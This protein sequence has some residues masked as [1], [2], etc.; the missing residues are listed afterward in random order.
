MPQG[1]FTFKAVKDVA[2][3]GDKFEQLKEEA[4]AAQAAQ[5]AKEAAVLAAA[6]ERRRQQEEEAEARRQEVQAATEKK[7]VALANVRRI[8]AAMKNLSGDTGKLLD[9]LSAL[10]DEEA[11]LLR[12]LA[13][14]ELTPEE[15]AA[16][17]A[18][19]AEI[20]AERKLLQANLKAN[21]LDTE[22]AEL[23]R[24]L[25]ALD[26]EEAELM[27]RL[28]A[29]DLSPEEEAAIRKRLA[30]IAA[31]RGVLLEQLAAKAAEQLHAAG[32]ARA[33]ELAAKLAA[34]ERKLGML[35]DEEAELL[36][37]LAAGDLTPEEEAAIRKRLAEIAAEREAL[38]REKS[39]ILAAEHAARIA[40][41]K[42]QDA[43]MEAELKRKLAALDDEEAELRRRLA[44][45]DLTPEEEAAIRK[46]LAEIEAE[47]ASLQAQLAQIQAQSEMADV[48]D[49]LAALDDEEA[50]LLRRLAAG[51]L[52][53]EEEAAIRKRLAEIAA[54]RQQ[55]LEQQLSA[56][57]SR[58]AALDDEEAELLRRLAA[59]D[60]TPEEEAAIRKRLAEIE[61]ERKALRSKIE[62]QNAKSA[63][64][65][66]ASEVAEL[67]RKLAALD[68]EE[69]EL[70]RRL[71][72]GD[73]TPE[74][75]A[76]I[77]KRLAEIE[78]E[79]ASLQAQ[80]LEAEVRSKQAQL[81]DI[82]RKLAALDDEEAELLRRLAAGDLTP[83]EEAAIR[84]RLAEIAAE[85]EA[86]LHLREATAEQLQA[87]ETAA[88][89]AA[90]AA[91]AAEENLRPESPIGPL[92]G[93]PIYTTACPPAIN[94]IWT[95]N[96]RSSWAF[97]A[98]DRGAS[99]MLTVTRTRGG[100]NP[101]GEVSKRAKIV[102]CR[103]CLHG[104]CPDC[105]RTM[106]DPGHTGKRPPHRLS[107]LAGTKSASP[108][109]QS[110]RAA[111]LHSGF[112]SPSPERSSPKKLLPPLGREGAIVLESRLSTRAYS[113][114]QSLLERA[115]GSG[116]VRTSASAVDAAE[117]N[118]ES[119]RASLAQ[120]HSHASPAKTLS[121][122]G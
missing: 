108:V 57:S 76:A 55:L 70:R 102:S 61:A 2:A 86:L 18:R 65:Q 100:L 79:R 98:K 36:R 46:R 26:E 114:S 95:P 105:K 118:R 91:A 97:H 80:L 27:R 5:E 117:S 106:T 8:V 53:P 37:R 47:R 11:E 99:R 111:D 13:S 17:R 50:E 33:L 92:G 88:A 48:D 49:R 122:P 20:E 81:A 120:R 71:A 3:V 69:A 43:A 30:E 34:I 10:D 64:Y 31:E 101:L 58:L 38:L 103:H 73:L 116:Q 12:R 51:D 89:E 41:R 62:S 1:C 72:A 19:L 87:A 44:A 24:K 16:V 32:D 9:K 21:R 67:K 4:R 90:A 74:E 15:E 115:D 6:E 35:D 63:G 96:T 85:R 22:I 82:D 25:A 40:Q 93:R 110:D 77:R 107:R 54:E 112:A 52:T 56:L 94:P 42:L 29:G 59:G 7:K 14:G 84:K 39:S 23:N 66:L 75:E 113:R 121:S 109:V 60:L 104:V 68:D 83:E 78:A 119:R 28:A 45:G